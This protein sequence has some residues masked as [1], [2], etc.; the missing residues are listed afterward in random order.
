MIIST[1]GTPFAACG[2]TGQGGGGAPASGEWAEI[3]G[4]EDKARA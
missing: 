4:K 2:K 1:F 3:R